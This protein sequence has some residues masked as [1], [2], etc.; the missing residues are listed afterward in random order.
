MIPR[1]GGHDPS[2]L[3]K[4]VAEYLTVNPAL[5]EKRRH[6]PLLKVLRFLRDELGLSSIDELLKADTRSLCVAFQKWVNKRLSETSI[7]TIRYEIY[8]ARSF[9]SFYEVEIPLRKIKVPRK[10]AKTRIDRIPSVGELQRLISFS[11]SPRMRLCLMTMALTGM[12]LGE[13]LGLR[14]EH[15]DLGRGFIIIPPEHTKTGVGREVP[16][17][18]ELRR[19]LEHYFRTVF[20]HDRGFLFGARGNPEKRIP[21]NRFYEQYRRLLRRTGLDAKTP[22]GSAYALHPH[23]LRKF[24]RTTLEAAGVNKLLIDLWMGHNSGV[25]KRYYLPTSEI[26]KREF[27]KAD[28]ALQIFGRR[29]DL[30]GLGR[31]VEAAT[32]LASKL[33]EYED[34]LVTSQLFTL[35]LVENA[36]LHRQV[37][38]EQGM[39]REDPLEI[40]RKL[41]ALRREIKRL[42]GKLPP[43]KLV[44]LNR[45]ASSLS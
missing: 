18:T 22:D 25:E 14:R 23:V 7:K 3:D 11:R 8:L 16:I 10:A 27:E 12:R 36:L 6:Y 5:L 24:Y 39:S 44:E 37:F 28:H 21:A 35:K 33:E 19:E 4:S 26:I 31:E 42:E 2:S 45:L 15:V 17:P 1:R 9:F 29:E 38:A 41:A 30:E 32:D 34:Q 13:C 40:D 43:A 20:K